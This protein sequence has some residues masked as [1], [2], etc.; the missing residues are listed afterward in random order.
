MINKKLV[1]T[2]G[3][4]VAL[5]VVAVLGATSAFAQG[6][7]D[8]PQPVEGRGPGRGGGPMGGS[9]FEVAAQALGMTTDELTAA[10]K[11]GKTLEQ[12]AEAQGVEFADVQAAMQTARDTEMRTRIRQA[13]DDGEITQ[14]HADWLLEGLDKGFLGSKGGFSMGFGAPRG[15]GRGPAPDGAQPTQ[16]GG[17]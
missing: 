10:L 5:A 9:G 2:G 8:P 16:E 17:Q 12:V 15:P 7:T 3:L 4:L 1:L 6:P 11:E 14:E 13:L